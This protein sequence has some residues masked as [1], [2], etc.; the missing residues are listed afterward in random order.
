[1]SAG[2]TTKP[3]AASIGDKPRK[4]LDA[5]E[6]LMQD[7]REVESLFRHFDSLGKSDKEA[8]TLL[9]RTCA[10]LTIYAILETEIFYPAVHEATEVEEIKD[11]LDAGEDRLDAISELAAAVV[12]MEAA[13][14]KRDPRVKALSAQ[15]LR[16]IAEEEAKLFPKV[17][18]LKALDV[19][20]VTREMKARKR[21]LI[22]AAGVLE[23]GAEAA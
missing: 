16:H 15:V 23:E 2:A 14:T 19:T 22:A 3:K 4:A 21:E 9:Q 7:H 12:E 8:G 5:V 20:K 13:Q 6:M 17:Q 1:V 11:L 18:K 10:E